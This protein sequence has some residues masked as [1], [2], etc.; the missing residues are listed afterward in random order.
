MKEIDLLH[1]MDRESWTLQSSLMRHIG[2]GDS[3]MVTLLANP[4]SV[5]CKVP[6]NLGLWALETLFFDPHSDGTKWTRPNRSTMSY[7]LDQM[8]KL[9]LL[10][11]LFGGPP[12]ILEVEM[13]SSIVSYQIRYSSCMAK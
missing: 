12:E 8:L 2:N 4:L 5:Y 7:T 11:C 6:W 1:Q 10:D 13:L 3:T 9:E